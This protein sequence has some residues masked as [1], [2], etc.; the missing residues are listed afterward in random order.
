MF[1]T[2]DTGPIRA[3]AHNHIHC[4]STTSVDND[5]VDWSVQWTCVLRPALLGKPGISS[6]TTI[7]YHSWVRSIN[8]NV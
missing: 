5:D 1:S 2:G 8:I 4:A 6:P 3:A 7:G